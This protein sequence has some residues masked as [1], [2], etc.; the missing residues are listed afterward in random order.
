MTSRALLAALMLG[1]APVAA[2][3]LETPALEPTLGENSAYTLTKVDAAG[4]DTITK[5]EYQPET[6]EFTP[7]YY[8]VDYRQSEYGAPY[9]QGAEIKY[10]KHVVLD[11]GFNIIQESTAD[12]YDIS[13][14]V[15]KNNL[16]DTTQVIVSE[17]NLSVTKDFVDNTVVIPAA[18]SS[19][20]A[21][22]VILNDNN[23]IKEISGDFVNNNAIQE[24]DVEGGE[25]ENEYLI[26]IANNTGTIDSIKGDFIANNGT[27]IANT[28]GTIGEINSNF[29]GC[30]AAGQDI[31]GNNAGIMNTGKINNVN[32]N[33][34]GKIIGVANS[35]NGSTTPTETVGTIN[36]LS[37]DF[38]MNTAGVLNMGGQIGTVK[39]DFIKNN[40]AMLNLAGKIDSING[41]FNENNGALINAAGQIGNVDANFLNNKPIT[42]QDIE[43]GIN[44]TI[45]T[46]ALFNIAGS[47]GGIKGNFINNT[48]QFE[49]NLSEDLYD[50]YEGMNV[51]IGILVESASSLASGGSVANTL[52]AHSGDINANFIGNTSLKGNSLFGGGAAIS[53][54][55]FSYSGD[56]TGNFINNKTI[57]ESGTVGG[58]AVSNS[59]AGFIGSYDE[60]TG[61]ISYGEIKNSS[62]LN[63][64]AEVKDANGQAAGGAIYSSTSLN[65]T[66]DNGDSVFSGNK[67]ITGTTEDQNAIGMYGIRIENIQSIQN[68]LDEYIATLPEDQQETTR[69]EIEEMKTMIT[70]QAPNIAELL[71]KDDA[72]LST[73]KYIDL[74]GDA[75]AGG[76]SSDSGDTTE[77]MTELLNNIKISDTNQTKL[78]LKAQNG[79]TIRFDDKISGGAVVLD[80]EHIIEKMENLNQSTEE[81]PDMTE[82]EMINMLTELLGD[83]TELK[84]NPETAYELTITGDETGAVILNNDV[85]NAHITLENT[86]LYLGKDDA[87]NQSQ[88]LSLDSGTL[89]MINGTAGTMHLPEFNLRGYVDMMVDV[90]LANKTMDRIT[91]DTY[92]EVTGN[93]N[94]AG[95]N[96]TSDATSEST[97]ILFADNALKNNVTYGGASELPESG[98]QT[99]A[100]TP[101]YKYNVNYDPNR[102]DGGY[103]VFSGGP[104]GGADN[105]NPAVLSSTVASQA[106]NQSA[107]N[108]VFHYTYE[109]VDSFTKLP[110]FERYAKINANKYAMSTDFNDNMPSYAEQLYNKGVWFK[111][112]TTFE[113]LPLKNGPK[114]DAITYG[115]LV[116]FDTDFKELGNGWHSVFSGFA[117]YVGSSLNYS[118]VDSTMNGGLLGFTETFYKG[119]FWTAVSATAGASVGETHNMY[120][121]ED[122]TS[123]LAGVG[124]KTGYN[125]EFKEGKFIIQPIMYLGYTFVNTFDYKNSAGVNIESDPLHTIQINPSVR[126]IANLKGGWQPYASVGMVWNLMN[127]TKAT[128]NNV[129]LPEMSVKPYVEYGVGVQRNWADKFTAFLQAMIR[130][131]GRNGVSLTGGFRF[132][133]GSNDDDSPKVKKE[134][135]SL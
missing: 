112:F 73:D 121:K 39:G 17:D 109:H 9:V 128:A 131:G 135:K 118:G 108:E 10:Y 63:N 55:L 51:L 14:H 62:F 100:F 74:I 27:D 12:D 116:G 36:N 6:G 134:I 1:V 104:A 76:D 95:I 48:S 123:L 133:L 78:T 71:E 98:F 46:P 56:I 70:E 45:G 117:G 80:V 114:V 47:V 126:F 77:Q 28:S 58:G 31:S 54:T 61:E 37:G 132:M 96:L 75:L 115:S 105:F 101:I 91:A 69:Q 52:G 113:S 29:I 97:E 124:S 8:R 82:D 119:N 20:G 102:T 92:G 30:G 7:V 125:F 49:L 16:S 66:A 72:F 122:Y 79:G 2:A 88:S 24:P 129:R 38:L 99:T 94:V 53:N 21:T 40:L 60:E 87:L 23:H 42:I 83:L 44:V 4:E 81:N 68:K 84:K 11:P 90:D 120:G 33:F 50:G 111:P 106:A 43:E 22:A 25:A 57:A 34:M 85:E 127:E 65:I 103:F 26:V 5:F 18:D 13:Y 3:E 32:S 41:E 89:S 67:T 19:T 110:A 86:N 107:L 59:L 130:N 35:S 15:D 93:L 64:T